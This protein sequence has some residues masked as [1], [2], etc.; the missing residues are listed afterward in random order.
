LTAI[1]VLGA[2][3][4]G[5]RWCNFGSVVLSDIAWTK[6]SSHVQAEWPRVDSW[7]V[8]KSLFS[9]WGLECPCGPV[10]FLS[11]LAIFLQGSS[12]LRMLGMVLMHNWN[13]S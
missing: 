3:V 8:Q 11:S 1:T 12:C 13:F 9:L 6:A 5:S 7:Q 10:S 4:A 2:V